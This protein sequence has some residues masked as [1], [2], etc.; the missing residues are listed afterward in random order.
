MFSKSS[1]A[2]KPVIETLGN[3]TRIFGISTKRRSR[4]KRALL[5]YLT[6][7]VIAEINN[8][9]IVRFSNHGLAVSWVHV[10]T[11]LGYEVDV[12]EWNDANFKPTQTYDLIVFHGGNNFKQIMSHVANKPRIIHW[13]TGSYWKFNNEAEDKRLADFTKRHGVK[14][15]RDRYIQVSEDEVNEAADGIIVLGDPSMRDTYP[16]SYKKVLTVN[17]ASYPDDHFL[18]T[19][20]DYEQ[21]RK[22][23]LFFAGAGNVHKGLDLLIDA[24]KDLDAH[25]TIVAH[26][27]DAVM[28]VFERE[29]KL[30]NIHL[31]GEVG[32]R[33]AAFYEIMD[34]N[35]FVILPS[36]SEGQAG[37][38]VECINQGLIPIV[39][40]ETRLDTRG[41]GRNWNT[42]LK[43]A[44]LAVSHKG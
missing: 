3:H 37:S 28:K 44:A 26:T 1:V 25:L 19:K 31:L 4:P 21:V 42:A 32:M 35:A 40:K 2:T 17:N 12:I 30:P 23:F 18:K 14:V 29:L 5:S 20:K 8:E 22:N 34:N 10:L 6:G 27:D 33:T 38:V 36:C 24:F 15:P 13:L 9:P 43:L 16:K 39:S 11:G 7:P 41:T